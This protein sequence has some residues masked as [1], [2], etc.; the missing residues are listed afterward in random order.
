MNAFRYRFPNRKRNCLL[1]VAG[2][3]QVSAATNRLV[4][5]VEI[6]RVAL[7]TEKLPGQSHVGVEVMGLNDDELELLALWQKEQRIPTGILELFVEGQ[8]SPVLG[9]VLV[10]GSRVILSPRFE[11]QP[12]IS[13]VAR[14]HFE[15]LPTNASS[16]PMEFHFSTP[17][18]SKPEIAARLENVYPS[19]DELPENVLR[20]YLQF[21]TPMARQRA[22]EH[23]EFVDANG[24]AIEEA[25][26]RIEQELWSPDGRRLTILFDPGRIKRGLVR[27]KELGAP[28]QAGQTIT[29]VVRPGWPDAAGVFVKQEFRKSFLVTEPEREQPTIKLWQLELPPAR[30]RKP[31]FVTFDRPFDFAQLQHAIQINDQF[32]KPVA[33]TISVGSGET[34]CSFVPDEG[35]MVGEFCLVVDPNLEDRAGNSLKKPFEIDIE[36]AAGNDPPPVTTRSFFIQ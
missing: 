3:L 30:S 17:A 29:L 1:I 28:F 16:T 23:I 35:W 21:V 36:S 10:E 12:G 27:N 4:A 18:L 32:G 6:P 31:L 5:Q 7:Q 26:I 14:F 11:L 22:Y 33:G 19:S 8:T 34:S 9:K 15:K 13:F 25:F 24:R 20:M 2:L